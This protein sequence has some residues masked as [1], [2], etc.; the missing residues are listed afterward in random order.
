MGE[1]PRGTLR[2][3]R[4]RESS[5]SDKLILSYRDSIIGRFVVNGFIE[6]TASW[7]KYCLRCSL[8]WFGLIL[9]LG[10]IVSLIKLDPLT[11]L[12]AIPKAALICL[13]VG[14]FVGTLIELFGRSLQ[15]VEGRRIALDV[16]GTTTYGW[17]FDELASAQVFPDS[18]GYCA[19]ELEFTNQD[20]RRPKSLRVISRLTERDVDDLRRVLSIDDG[21]NV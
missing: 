21:S 14:F 9:V 11:F 7:F 2:G 8:Q 5:E 18:S 12:H 10:V 20:R 15:I 3:V 13:G 1:N 19:I 17:A 6:A 16:P 4:K